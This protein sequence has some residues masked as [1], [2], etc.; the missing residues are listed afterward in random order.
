M[1]FGLEDHIIEKITHILEEQPKVDK[2]YIFG[3][4]AKG[5]Y[6][7]DSDIDMA[8]KGFELTMED[9]LKMSA[10]I[11]KLGIGF[12]VDLIDYDSIKEEALREHVDRVGAEF[13][14][15]W[16]EF[17][18]SQVLIDESISYGIVQPGFHD[19]NGIPIIRVNNIKSGH[20]ATDDIL[21]VNPEIEKGYQ[22]TRLEGGELLITVVGTV[23][24]C[25]IVPDS[26]KGWNVARAISVARIKP[27]FDKKFIKYS[28]RSEEIRH[29]L[30]GNTN[31]TV[32]PTLNLSSLKNIKLRAPS[33][34]LQTSIV[35][36][37]SSL[38][39]KIDLLHRQNIT[40]E[41]MAEALFKKWII[42]DNLDDK[43]MTTFASLIETTLGGEWGENVPDEYNDT[44]VCCIRG[45]DIADLQNGLATRTPARFVKRSKYE[46][47]QPK[48]GDIILEISGGT[49][50]QSTGRAIYIGSQNRG[51]FPY[52]L[53]F[54]NFC[55]LIR[56]KKEEYS[57]FIYLY[58][59]YL[60][61]Q[62]EFFN[63][64][65][66]SSGIKNL[67]YKFLL[68]E[69]KYLFPKDERDIICL[70]SQFSTY[71]ETIDKNKS[72]IITLIN[73]RDE[74]LPKLLSGEVRVKLP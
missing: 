45:T 9:I 39:N 43:K 33:L 61:D 26:L 54:S 48:D 72:Q 19:I 70:N 16:R 12:E 36:I 5:N 73:L 4:R 31:D 64:E 40:L 69:L 38:D 22:R 52:P 55:R 58:L 42:K 59:K 10:A 20:I 21:K 34:S 50:D 66:G 1:K 63:L 44:Q 11:D 6:R 46:K 67:D 68:F 62:E 60:Y 49:D 29:Q 47:I 17:T 30:Y 51:L 32:Q 24:E 65:N 27:N 15:S 71:F 41:S 8:V 14:S 53:I 7:P 56:P 57:Y 25:A 35:Q 74:L 13:Y 23:G 37:L 28:F 2:A 3:S 18:F